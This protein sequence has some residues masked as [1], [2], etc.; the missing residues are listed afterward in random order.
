MHLMISDQQTMLIWKVSRS[1]LDTCQDEHVRA[2]IFLVSFL[3]INAGGGNRRNETE[4]KKT[5]GN[6]AFI[7]RLLPTM[8]ELLMLG[9]TL[10]ICPKLQAEP[11]PLY[12][13][14]VQW[15]FLNGSVAKNRLQCRRCRFTPWV[16][17]IPWRR[18]W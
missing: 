11:E 4:E 16:G 12:L 5:W 14:V 18:K 7:T 9:G 10:L 3:V 2:G 13:W 15:G 1:F 17:K 8:G 6:N